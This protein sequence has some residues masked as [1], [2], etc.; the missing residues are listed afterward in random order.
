VKLYELLEP[1]LEV[2]RG[3]EWVPIVPRQDAFIMNFGCAIEI[4]TK[5]TRT[6]VAAVAHRVV[7]QKERPDGIA[8]RFSYGLFVDSNL[9][10]TQCAGL[11]RFD[12]QAGLILATD[13]NTF[14]DNILLNTYD[15]DTEGL[16]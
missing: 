14:L 6:P 11:Y 2:Q 9:D 15:R 10:T 1:G 7:E 3:R 16:Y 8:D 12:P 4:L 13:F 5:A